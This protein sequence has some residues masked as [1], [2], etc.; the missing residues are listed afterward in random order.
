MTEGW[1][2]QPSFFTVSDTSGSALI[3]PR[4]EGRST[5][6]IGKQGTS[7]GRWIGGST[8]AGLIND[9]GAV[10]DWAWTTANAADTTLRP[11]A[12]GDDGETIALADRGVRAKDAPPSNSHCCER[13][14]WNERCTIETNLG[15]V[16]ELFHAK[17]L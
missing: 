9:A 15:W 14:T 8:W 2:A 13:G 11:L 17:K 10:V 7:H 3:Q 12:L 1:L 4:R 5:Q 6:Q 16:T